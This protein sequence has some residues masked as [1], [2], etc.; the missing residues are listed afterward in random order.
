MGHHCCNKQKVKR[1]LWSPEEDEKLVNYITTHGHGCWSSVPKQAGLQRC[2]KSCRL[3]WI[4]YLRPELKRGSFSEQ[5]ERTIIDVHRILGNRWAQIAKHLPGR[6][7]N[8]VKNFWNSCIKKKLI[9]QGLDPKTHNLLPSHQFSS[10]KNNNACNNL[11]IYQEPTSIFS[12]NSQMRDGPMNASSLF[13][14]LPPPPPPPPPPHPSFAYTASTQIHTP[15]H[16][17]MTIINP[18]YEYQNPNLAWNVKGQ[19]SQVSFD[20]ASRSS[21]DQTTPISSSPIIPSGFGFLDENLMWGACGV[22]PF[23]PPRQEEMQP[24][25][26]EKRAQ[27]VYETEFDETNEV[28]GGGGGHQDMQI[29]SSFN[30]SNFDLDF[31]ESTMMSCGMYCNSSSLDQLAWD[32]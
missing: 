18:S 24:P 32:F 5:E 25:Q 16:E 12:V 30:S 4:N 27:E 17:T 19:N 6:T 10:N 1:G 29:G 7:D 15:F 20:F 9:A 26:Q 31:V 2:G 21:I 14:T 23:E 28:K 8:E 11:H 13:I 3:R 22:E